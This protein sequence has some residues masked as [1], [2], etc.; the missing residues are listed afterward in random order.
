MEA[1]GSGLNYRN[2]AP[3]MEEGAGFTHVACSDPGKCQLP[4]DGAAGAASELQRLML[5]RAPGKEKGKAHVRWAD[6][7]V[8]DRVP[9]EPTDNYIRRQLCPAANWLY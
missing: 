1:G 6:V 7:G 9:H 4:G 3:E 2:H 5:T 8:G